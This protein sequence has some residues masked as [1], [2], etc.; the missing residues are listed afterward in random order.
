[1]IIPVLMYHSISDDLSPISISPKDFENHL[2]FFKNHNYETVNLSDIDQI[3]KAK[4]FIITF[5]DGYKDNLLTALPL[6]KK[7]NFKATCF[8]T[9]NFIGKTNKWDENKQNFTKK[10]IMG[11]DDIN[12]WISNNMQIGSHTHNHLNLENLKH[13]DV[14]NEL[15]ISKKILVDNF[16][17]DIDCVSYPFGRLNYNIYNLTKNYYKK[18]VTT[19]RS[20]YN[21]S[22]HSDLLIPRIN[23]SKNLSKFKLFLKIKTIYEDIKFDKKKLYM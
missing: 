1:M 10:I 3:S 15:A 9:T 8:I 23:M 13:T 2:I 4:P 19:N 12:E 11:F 16:K 22:L 14:V 5:D 18:G 20:R 6:L 21:T 7:Y 17:I